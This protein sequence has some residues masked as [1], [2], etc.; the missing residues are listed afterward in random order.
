MDCLLSEPKALLYLQWNWDNG[1]RYLSSLYSSGRKGAAVEFTYMQLG[2]RVTASHLVMSQFLE[3]TPQS[4][5]C[6]IFC[7]SS[8]NG[9]SESHSVMSDSLWPH[10]LHSL[11]NSAGQNTGVGSLSLLQGIFPTQELNP[12]GFFTSWATRGAQKYRSW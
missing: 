4:L 10:G 12:G 6:A 1:M 7:T 8:G 11:W 3:S 9:E 5:L 2:L